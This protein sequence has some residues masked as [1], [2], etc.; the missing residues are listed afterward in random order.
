MAS[1]PINLF[2]AAVYFCLAVAVIA[3]FRSGLLRSMATIF[4]YLAA[5]A[6]AVA[7]TPR[8]A[9]FLIERAHIPPTETWVV[10]VGV[11]FA[12]G[13]VLGALLRLAVSELV[14][15]EVS[16]PDRVAGAML[17]TVRVALL[18]VLMVVIF[19]RLIPPGREPE[20][21]KGSR[22]RPVLSAAGQ[23]GLKSLPP[24]VEDY[25]DRLKRERGL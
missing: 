17:G 10:Y 24:D 19:D 18:A 1:L 22:L 3:G 7:L 4:G 8:L 15:A 2:D 20:F 5:M 13:V 21:L 11:F 12:S 6:I 14:G 23:Q 9:Q 16:A 25:I